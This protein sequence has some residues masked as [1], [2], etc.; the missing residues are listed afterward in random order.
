[1]RARRWRGPG[2]GPCRRG[3]FGFHADQDLVSCGRPRLDTEIVIADP[4]SMQ[5]C[6]AGSI[7]EIWVAGAS[8]ARGYR[9]RPELSAAT[10]S[11]H[12]TDTGEGPYLR[13]GDLGFISNGELFV[14][15]RIK[16]VII[17]RGQNYYPQDIEQTVAGQ[18]SWLPSG[19]RRGILESN[20][21]DEE[22]LM[23]VQ[24]VERTA[25]APPGG[26]RGRR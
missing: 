13:T 2:R 26:R 14:N 4:H 6:P 25:P 24:E 12:L 3:P 5:R 19:L 20:V 1:M 17:I 9:N 21:N 15:G 16:D 10:F 11:A 22:R 8:V 23:V 18:L 7:G